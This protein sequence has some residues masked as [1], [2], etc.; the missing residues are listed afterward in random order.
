[1]AGVPPFVPLVFNPEM[2]EPE[3][4]ALENLNRLLC[5]TNIILTNDMLN[6][7]I[8]QLE[9]YESLSDE[10]YLLNPHYRRLIFYDQRVLNM[11]EYPNLQNELRNIGYKLIG[12]PMLSRHDTVV[13]EHIDRPRPLFRRDPFNNN[14]IEPLPIESVR[15]SEYVFNPDT[16]E[17]VP[18]HPAVSYVSQI[19]CEVETIA[20]LYPLYDAL[21]AL[22]LYEPRDLVE[23]PFERLI[24]YDSSIFNIELYPAVF[25]DI[26][27]IIHRYGY[28]LL[29]L[30]RLERRDAVIG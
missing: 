8:Q 9:V 13:D 2:V 20:D 28:G 26:V 6:N 14:S 23:I 16:Q 5:N 21:D 15:V 3:V 7:A 24:V 22:P 18:V 10:E 17:R 29:P 4:T 19:L 30:P 11:S 27:D 25:Q 1:M 12:L